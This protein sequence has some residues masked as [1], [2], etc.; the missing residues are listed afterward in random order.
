M[1]GERI[2]NLTEAK[3]LRRE[4]QEHEVLE[5]VPEIAALGN[6]QHAVT[7]VGMD[8]IDA[9]F[10]TLRSAQQQLANLHDELYK[11]L[12]QA[13]ELAGPLG[14]GTSPVTGPMRR[15][16][17]DRVDMEGGVQAALV[18]YLRE[19]NAVQNAIVQTLGTYEGVETE[20]VDRLRRQASEIEEI[21]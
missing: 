8:G 9:D 10:A 16:F 13:A 6:V 11:S 15:A 21:A 14:D 17:R 19:L 2:D 20:T 4:Y 1:A 7:G 12:T 5:A 18:Q 3:L